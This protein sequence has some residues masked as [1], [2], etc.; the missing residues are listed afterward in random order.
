LFEGEWIAEFK[1][2]FNGIPVTINWKVVLHDNTPFKIKLSLNDSVD[3]GGG[4]CVQ[5]SSSLVLMWF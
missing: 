4:E 5:E 3:F 1:D 2:C